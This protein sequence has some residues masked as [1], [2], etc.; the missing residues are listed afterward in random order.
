MHRLNL[1]LI[2]AG[3]AAA[4]WLAPAGAQAPK[5]VEPF[6]GK[7]LT[8]WKLKGPEDRSHWKAGTA[9]MDTENPARLTFR[10]GGERAQLVNTE[11]GG[12]DIFTAEKFGDCGI[13]LEFM[14]PKGSNS[15]IYLMGE[16]EIQVFDSYGKEKIG[17][18]DL[19]AIYS[20]KVPPVNAAKEPGRW[21]KF[22]ILFR[23][24]RFKDGKKVENARFVKVEL[25]DQTLHENVE[26]QGPTPGGLT[27]KEAPT[28]PLMF[29]GDHG[30]VAY[31]DIRI[32]PMKLD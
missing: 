7:D 4:V 9:E 31:R 3:L 12:V 28:G 23:A 16:Y 17:P 18:G 24:P 5:P 26:V 8:G 22:R 27:G 1:F 11:G 15:G 29:Q 20:A 21:Q 25:N 19:G 14:V 6:N 2:P 10:P 30:P 32:T 13:E